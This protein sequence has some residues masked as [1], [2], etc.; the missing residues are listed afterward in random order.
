MSTEKLKA[1]ITKYQM[2]SI[3]IKRYY[4]WQ[5]KEVGA[6]INDL[7]TKLNLSGFWC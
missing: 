1:I 7:T 4:T 5:I 2:M 6:L 3:I